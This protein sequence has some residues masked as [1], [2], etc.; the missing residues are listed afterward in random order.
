M[1]YQERI[2]GDFNPDVNDYIDSTGF[3]PASIHPNVPSVLQQ[4]IISSIL[5]SAVNVTFV[6]RT[7]KLAETCR[8]I[9]GCAS[10]SCL[11]RTT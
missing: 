4:P 7:V 2:K 6:P 10:D 5:N 11:S 1:S 3:K 8:L 9:F